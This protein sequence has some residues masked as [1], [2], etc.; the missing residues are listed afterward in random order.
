MSRTFIMIKPDAV[1][2]RHVGEIITRIEKEG[3]KILALRYLQLSV[4]DAKQFYKVHAG[5]PFYEELCKDMSAGPI[6]AA[7]LERDNAVA[8]WRDVIGATDPKE[9]KPGTIRALYAE[10]KGAN[11]VHGSDSDENA[12]LEISFFFKGFELV[13]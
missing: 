4:D 10:S 12:A 8:H 11:S 13:K 2:N 6:V 1:R 3:F 9:A 5:R 7:A